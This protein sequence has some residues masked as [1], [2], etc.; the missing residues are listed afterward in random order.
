MAPYSARRSRAWPSES[1]RWRWWCRRCRGLPRRCGRPSRSWRVPARV[2]TDADEKDEAFRTARAALTKSGTST[3]ELALAGVPMVAA[4]KVPLIEELAARLLLNVPSVILANL[5]ARRKRGAGISAA[6]LH[7]GAA[8][9]G[10]VAAAGRYAG[11]APADSRRSPAW[12]PS[13]RSARPARATARRPW[14]SISRAAKANQHAKL[15]RL[16]PPSGMT[17]L[18]GRRI[19]VCHCR[20][21]D[22]SL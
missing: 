21:P 11:T 17:C 2:V 18:G 20:K 5:V 3:L 4:Y 9:R 19:G 7:A 1:A 13:W 15:P 14:C 12:M 22:S 6:R 10:A 8:R 16:A